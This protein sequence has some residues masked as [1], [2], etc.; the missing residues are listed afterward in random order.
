MNP[1]RPALASTVP[2]VSVPAK[3]PRPPT[4]SIVNTDH[5][6]PLREST[7]RRGFT[8]IE[9]LVVIAI[10]AIL[11]GLLL[12]A[13][14]KV[15]EAAKRIQL[16][17]DLQELC[18]AM[19]QVFNLDGDYPLDITDARLLPFLSEELVGRI[20]N[21]I[22]NNQ[23]SFPYYII[24]VRP[25]TEGEKA[26]WDFR[27][28]SGFDYNPLVWLPTGSLFDNGVAVDPECK[29]APAELERYG[30]WISPAN[31]DDT[32]VRYWWAWNKPQLPPPKP[33]KSRYNLSR[34]LVTAQ[35]AEMVTP[36]L[37]EY[38]ELSPQVRPFL[39]SP[40]NMAV[41]LSQYSPLWFEPFHD[42]LQLDDA[43]IDALS[44]LEVTDLEGDPAF[45]FSYESL[46]MLSTLYSNDS[47]VTNALVS[48]LDAAE[49]AE[50]R[51]NGKARAGKLG[52]FR[53]Q[54]RAESGKALTS[55]A[56]RTILA[57]SSTL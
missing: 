48:K 16:T 17:S 56:A 39:Q 49:D 42:I 55:D 24:S 1:R 38:P 21:S 25:G 3:G 7:A 22:A 18:L 41:V 43:E 57:I 2:A 15:R 26:T 4:A 52:A 35:A 11:I 44:N 51:G 9:L 47:G 19:D 34:A 8:L 6:R 28:A 54:V 53:N 37:E 12:P 23:T 29:V 20:K 46:R 30:V 14:T 36:I 50:S 31:V 13:V 10:I 40:E 5:R 33:R 45:L 27:I 32:T